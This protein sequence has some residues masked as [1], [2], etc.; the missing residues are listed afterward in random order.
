VGETPPDVYSLTGGG[1]EE[2]DQSQF[3]RAKGL[4]GFTGNMLV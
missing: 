4:S 3:Q 1:T 2:E